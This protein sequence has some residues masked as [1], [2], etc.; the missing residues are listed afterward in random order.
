MAAAAVPVYR[1]AMGADIGAGA[2]FAIVFAVCA[3]AYL[4]TL[5]IGFTS[6]WS[7]LHALIRRFLPAGLV[8][9]RIRILRPL[10]GNRTAA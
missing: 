1:F 5:R 4:L 2:V 7:D 3:L 6:A 8:A 9:R 10:A